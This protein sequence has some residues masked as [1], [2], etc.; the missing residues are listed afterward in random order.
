MDLVSMNATVIHFAAKEITTLV[1][2]FI[3]FA[4]QESIAVLPMETLGSPILSDA[5][6][7]QMSIAAHYKLGEKMYFA[8]LATQCM[9]VAMK[10]SSGKTITAFAIA[11]KNAALV[12]TIIVTQNTVCATAKMNAV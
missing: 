4:I 2:H 5:N 1:I 12:M 11:P 10:N 9:N 7:T 6:A 3:A 8:H